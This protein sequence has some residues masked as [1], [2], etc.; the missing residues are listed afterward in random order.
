[1]IIDASI[2]V[3]CFVPELRSE[4][5]HEALA[6]ARGLQAPDL[7]RIEFAGS[8]TRKFR[9]REIG[10]AEVNEALADFTRLGIQFEPSGS[11]LDDAVALSLAER[12][13]LYDCL[14]VALAMR[15]GAM[16]ATFDTTLAALA[17]RRDVPIWSPR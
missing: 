14:Y 2:A 1:M 11:L 17:S 12:H 5:A 10:L 3:A 16:F 15:T 9:R 4:A 8:L 13:P 6:E 7:M